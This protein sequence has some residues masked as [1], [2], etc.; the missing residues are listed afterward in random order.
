MAAGE[1]LVADGVSRTLAGAGKERF[2]YSTAQGT[3]RTP[4]DIG[5]LV[6]RGYVIGYL[7]GSPVRAPMDDHLRGIARDG[8]L[9]P[10]G[11]TLVEI[12]PRG[13]Q[14]SWTGTDERGQ[15]IA[16]AVIKAIERARERLAAI[17]QP[18]LH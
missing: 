1:T 17:P 11:V 2:V 3:W 14:A 7:D 13:R 15:T 12:D 8:T 18:T 4:L 16:A 6:F 10:G 5:A 9:A